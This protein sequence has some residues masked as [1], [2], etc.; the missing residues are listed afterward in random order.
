MNPRNSELFMLGRELLRKAESFSTLD[1]MIALKSVSCC[2]ASAKKS[3]KFCLLKGMQEGIKSAYF[4][5]CE[6]EIRVL[7]VVEYQ[8]AGS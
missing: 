7:E 4:R 8:I 3:S 1:I 6:L 5:N 2:L